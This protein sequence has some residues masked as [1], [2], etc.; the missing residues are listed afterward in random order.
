MR[1]VAQAPLMPPDMDTKAFVAATKETMAETG[2]DGFYLLHNHPSGDPSPSNAD[3]QVTRDFQRLL[4][5]FR[6][7]VVINS[8]KYAEITPN[9]QGINATKVHDLD[10]G[11]DKLIAASTPHD[12]L[13]QSIGYGNDL[14]ILGKQLQQPGWI[15]VIGT[16]A[17]GKVRVVVDYPASATKRDAKALMAM[18]RRIQRQSGSASLFLIGEKAVLDT[19]IVRRA[20]SGGIVTDAIDENGSPIKGYKPAKRNKP[21]ASPARMVAEDSKPLGT[22]P[23]PGPD[24]AGKLVDKEGITRDIDAIKRIV[25]N[26][27]KT[28]GSIVN[29]GLADNARAAFYTMDS[30]LRHLAKRYDSEA[31][32]FLANQF[33]AQAGKVDKA[34]GETYHEAVDREG[35]GRAGQV[36]RILEPFAGNKEAM[37]RIGLMLRRPGE[38]TS[39]RKTEAEAAAKI[40]KLLKDTIEY[41]KSAG[42]EIGEV[43][44]GYF[45]R[46]MDVEK[47]VKNRGLFLRQ[48]T[49]LYRLHGA[50]NPQASAEAWLAR[51]FDQ[52]AGLDGGLDLA[53]LTHDARPAGV[54]RKTSK[55]REFGKDADKL[56]GEFYDN[57]TGQVLTA[58]MLGAA[59]K[60]EE[61]RRFGG[62]KLETLLNRIKKDIRKSGEDAGETLDTISRMIATNLGRTAALGERTRGLTSILHTA[63]QLGTLDR[64]T[65]TSLSEAMMGFVRGGPKYGLGM[66]TT[67]AREFGRQLRNA[68]P[69]EAGRMAEALGIATDALVGEALAARAG[70]ERANTT[71]RAQK[72]QQGYFR[73]TGLHQW[74]EGTRTA[75][76]RMGGHFLRDLAKD[77]QGRGAKRAAE[78]LTE[79][80]V[81]DPKAFA[82]WLNATGS[83]TV[84]SVTSAKAGAM[85]QQYRTALVRFANQT[86]MKP[87]RAEKPRWASHPV[88]SLFFALMSF[89][90]GFKKNVLDRTGRM[91]V[92]AAKEGDP[93]LLYPAFGLAGLFAVHTTVQMARE[94]LLGG[95]REN[96]E[97]GLEFADVLEALDRAG[98][99]GAASPLLNAVFGLKYR[100]GLTESLV[101]PVVG[102]P[103]DA[104]GKV[105][106]ATG[107]ESLGNSPNTNSAERA[108]AGAIF[109]VVMEPALE[110]YGVTRLKG[111]LAAGSVWGTGNREGG[112]LP[113][114]RDIFIE[115]V[116]GPKEE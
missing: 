111:P 44:D 96:D 27:I 108:A 69:S 4:P 81:K 79:L 65:I 24:L 32:T 17:R 19:P 116:A 22:K 82:D 31:I 62:D 34:V 80:G 23:D 35:F 67:S 1:E 3:R 45:P 101:G 100:R 59:K 78:Y 42:E 86:I 36:W 112:V 70:F 89:S 18:A 55:S 76:T 2:A 11:A 33:H 15:T 95:G 47:V 48:A 16:D 103:L 9:G 99:F 21:P 64:A 60:A 83:P 113:P 115:A 88:G 104:A 8:N 20:L 28:L 49:E 43:T 54:G 98:L 87:T 105:V 5:G 39:A 109:D 77:M 7:H 40:A 50:D 53:N 63:G 25:G 66:V 75:A 41:R 102:R 30:R 91:G 6:S 38:R 90:Y 56:L 107:G 85:E 58:Y 68:K 57:D 29:S 93:T 106:I 12:V 110:A 37:D 46:M 51:I 10:T 84:E 74:T 97:E 71:R 13:G 114:D 94:A 72:V 73:A 14:V 61:A 52:Y 26:P 92:R